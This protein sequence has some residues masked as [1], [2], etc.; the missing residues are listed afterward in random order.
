LSRRQRENAAKASNENRSVRNRKNT[1][2]EA[3]TDNKPYR[4]LKQHVVLLPKNLAQETYIDALENAQHDIVFAVGNA[5]TGKTYLATLFAIHA[6]KTGTIEKVVISRPTIAVDDRDIGFLPGTILQKMSPWTRPILDVF[7]EYFSVKEITAMVDEGILELCPIQYIRG[8]TF[9]N[10]IVIIDE[11]QN[12][13]QNS[14]LSILTR[15]GEGSRM[16]ITGDT[17]Q[18]DRGDENGLA[19]F[20]Q[21]FSNSHRIAVCHFGRKDVERH[22]VIGEILKLYGQE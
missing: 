6:L 1:Q 14:M 21:R 15:I 16:I 20:L 3:T 8:R 17:R 5:G 7:E 2:R 19:D 4:K 11:A 13:T 12:T 22:P 18:T 10:S 9:K